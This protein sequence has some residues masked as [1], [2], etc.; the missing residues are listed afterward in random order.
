MKLK[1]QLTQ[2]FRNEPLKISY[3]NHHKF[4]WHAK[5]RQEQER[6]QKKLS[7]WASKLCRGEV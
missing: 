7:K 1:E 2:V 6:K 5:E 3:C 4:D